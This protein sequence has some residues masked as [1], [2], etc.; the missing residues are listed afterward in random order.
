MRRPGS[1]GGSTRPRRAAAAGAPAPVSAA[2]P[3]D[4]EDHGV[5]AGAADRHQGRA[6]PAAPAGGRPGTARA[7]DPEL[8]AGL[9]AHPDLQRLVSGRV[10]A[11]RRRGQ[12]RR[13]RG[14]AGLGGHHRRPRAPCRRDHLRH[15]VPCHRPADRGAPARTRRTH[16]GRVLERQPAHLPRRH[17][18]QLPQ[19]VPPR[20]RGQRDRP[21]LP[22]VP[23]GVPGGVRDG[24]AAP[25][26]RTRHHQR[27]GPR[28]GAARL[29]RA[30]HG[31]AGGHGLVGRRLHELLPGA[32]GVASVNW[33]ASTREYRRATRRFDPAPYQLRTH[34]AVGPIANGAP[35][36]STRHATAI[37]HH[38]Q[39]R[40]LACRPRDNDARPV[41]ADAPPHP[42][43]SKTAIST[44]HRSHS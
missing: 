8:R 38:S 42:T 35:R 24:R 43:H 13:P 29:R 22:R 37:A 17:H 1:S 15:R 31:A 44:T 27:R 34:P 33:P 20:R 26:A 6:A 5:A 10:G 11:Q 14:A 4:V 25:D 2:G 21:Q 16:P 23:G 9:Q 41:A 30:A 32:D 7:A 28:R 19:P 3:G 40:S 39:T 12:R 36:A 18:D